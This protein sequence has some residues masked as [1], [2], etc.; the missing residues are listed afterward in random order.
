MLVATHSGPFHCDDVF[1]CALLRTFLEPELRCIR[2]RD[3]Q[4][5]AAADIAI[6]VGGQYDPARGRFDHH[7]REYD[8]PLSSAGMVLQWLSDEGKVSAALADTLRVQ[9]VT[10]I[11][12]VD[13]G[14]RQPDED[15][16]CLPTVIG[17]I[18]EQARSPEEFDARYAEAVQMCVAMLTGLRQAEERTEAA[19]AAVASAM[20]KAVADGT[21][22]MIFDQHYKWK[23]A[24]FEQGGADHPTDYTLFPDGDSWR[25]LAIPP[26]QESFDNK[27]PLPAQWAG[28]VDEELSR[29]IGVEGARFCHKNRFIAVFA[30]RAAAEAAIDKWGLATRV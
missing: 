26:E 10:Y 25:I 2:T 29:V 28:L 9:W 19:R 30:T 15:V 24:Y 7:Q 8:G 13:N 22:V 27:R 11:D 23:R 12:A 21:R 1:A 16:P 20:A 14:A 17:A 18:C 6:D 3:L 4:K 5:I